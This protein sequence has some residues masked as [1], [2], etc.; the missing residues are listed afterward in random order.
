MSGDKRKKSIEL[1]EEASKILAKRYLKV[2]TIF[3]QHFNRERAEFDRRYQKYYPGME[4]MVLERKG[5]VPD[6]SD[7]MWEVFLFEIL[8]PEENKRDLFRPLERED[9]IR[10]H[11]IMEEKLI[12]QFPDVDNNRDDKLIIKEQNPYS[13]LDPEVQKRI[14]AF[15]SG[16]RKDNKACYKYLLSCFELN[17]DIFKNKDATVVIDWAKGNKTYRDIESKP[18][19]KMLTEKINNYRREYPTK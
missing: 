11:L 17:R 1:S 12:E 14:T 16:K 2:S 18:T 10:F 7:E 3:L 13:K 6:S 5:H 15:L 4:R 8:D 9:F 19:N